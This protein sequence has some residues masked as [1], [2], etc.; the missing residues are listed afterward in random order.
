MTTGSTSMILRGRPGSRLIA[1]L[2]A[3][4]LMLAG[5]QNGKLAMPGFGARDGETPAEARMREDSSRFNATV[6]GGTVAGCGIGAVVAGLGCKMAGSDARKVRNCALAGCVVLGAA[7]A[8]DGYHTAKQQQASRDRVRTTQAMA[9]D[10]RQDNQKI[11]AFLESSDKVLADSRARLK[12]INAQVAARRISADQ[13]ATERRRI[14]QNRDLMQSTLDEMKQ[15]RDVYR[16]AAKKEPSG[17]GSRD[18][19]GELNQMNQ[20]IASLE[21][22]VRAMNAALGVTRS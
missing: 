1:A 11:Q 19:D 10:V 15:S 5:C 2:V 18:L 22:N 17:G 13:A 20:K 14:E 16:E 12:D 3:L 21:R 9:A 4:S 8:A 6:L 7:G